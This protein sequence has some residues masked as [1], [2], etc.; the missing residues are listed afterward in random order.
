M[1]RKLCRQLSD[2]AVADHQHLRPGG[3]LAPCSPRTWRWP[4]ALPERPPPWTRSSG[5]LI[6]MP[7]GHRHILGKDALPVPV[8]ADHLPVGAQV[9]VTLPALVA[10]AAPQAHVRGDAGR[11]TLRSRTSLPTATMVPL[12][13]CP[14][15]MGYLVKPFLMWII[16]PVSSSI[17]VAQKPGVRDLRQAPHRP[18]SLR[19]C[20]TAEYSMT[21]RL[22]KTNCFH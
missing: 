17:S 3:N 4:P 22:H 9:V 7:L 10:L 1:L 6:H 2:G 15:M 19:R 20:R 21:L 12:H 14:G 11:P 8:G 16:S 18:S 5:I 13:S